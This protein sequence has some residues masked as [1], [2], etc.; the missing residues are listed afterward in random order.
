MT[1]LTTL[2]YSI[3]KLKEKTIFRKKRTHLDRNSNKKSHK[4][5]IFRVYIKVHINLNE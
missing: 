2:V 1:I 3:V 5:P 4:S